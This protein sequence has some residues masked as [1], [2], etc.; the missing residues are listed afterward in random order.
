MS[1]TDCPWT[2]GYHGAA[3]SVICEGNTEQVLGRFAELTAR[4]AHDCTT[5]PY[6]SILS[7][8]GWMC[9]NT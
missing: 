1:V 9:V 3:G 4:P 5:I 6:F 8:T 7:K 2:G